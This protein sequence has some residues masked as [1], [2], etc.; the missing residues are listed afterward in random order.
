MKVIPLKYRTRSG[1]FYFHFSFEKAWPGGWTIYI[2][3]QPAY[4]GRPEDGHSTH[5]Y[6]IGSRPYIC[7]TGSL[8]HMGD[9]K[10]VAQA[11]AEKTEKYILYGEK[12]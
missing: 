7:W 10:R 1:R 4:G 12:F 8:Y 11:W 5:R 2:T 9:A 3:S 6:G